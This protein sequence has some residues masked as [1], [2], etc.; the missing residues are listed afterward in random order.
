MGQHVWHVVHVVVSPPHQLPSPP[1]D[2]QSYQMGSVSGTLVGFAR[3]P[4]VRQVPLHAVHG[5]DAFVHQNVVDVDSQTGQ[6]VSLV[7]EHHCLLWPQGF[8]DADLQVGLFQVDQ[9]HIDALSAPLTQLLAA[10]VRVGGMA[11]N[12]GVQLPEVHHGPDIFLVSLEH[13]HQWQQ[14]FGSAV[15]AL[16]LRHEPPVFDLL[17]ELVFIRA[18]CYVR[19]RERVEGQYVAVKS[20][21]RILIPA[22]AAA[23]TPGSSSP[24]RTHRSPVTVTPPSA[25]I[26]FLPSMRS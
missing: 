8:V 4:I 5:D 15:F 22:S 13:C 23:Q 16:V 9:G 19:R 3:Q 20:L 14:S 7:F 24:N 2:L 21:S 26:P 17:P 10:Q 12:V 11:L 25:A 6:A 1:P 18:T